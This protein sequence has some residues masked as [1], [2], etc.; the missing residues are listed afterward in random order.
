M[1][2]P[3]VI[4]YK[5][6]DRDAIL[7][8]CLKE[9]ASLIRRR[10]KLDHRNVS[11]YVLKILMNCVEFEEQLF[12]RL[13]RF[14]ELNRVLA[15]REVSLTGPSWRADVQALVR[16][17]C[18]TIAAESDLVAVRDGTAFCW[19]LSRTTTRKSDSGSPVWSERMGLPLTNRE[20]LARNPEVV[21][22]EAIPG[23][24]PASGSPFLS[25]GNGDNLD[26]T[27]WI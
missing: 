12:V 25:K 21:R 14:E 5:H 3:Y 7:F 2:S 15:R 16:L 18:Q 10:A 23:Q 19:R 17:I 13:T 6:H 26:G 20:V 4:Q 9:D 24:P 1:L 11:S 22:A 27:Q 8:S